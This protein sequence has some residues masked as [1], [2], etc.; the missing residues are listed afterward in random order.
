M[1]TNERGGCFEQRNCGA[2]E[3]IKLDELLLFALSPTGAAVVG[4]VSRQVEMSPADASGGPLLHQGQLCQERDDESILDEATQIDEGGFHEDATGAVATVMQGQEAERR[5]RVASPRR[6]DVMSSYSPQTTGQLA[7]QP[8]EETSP[9]RRAILER[10]RVRRV[11][12]LA[13]YA[14]AMVEQGEEEAVQRA[15]DRRE[16]RVLMEEGNRNVRNLV[17]LLEQRVAIAARTENRAFSVVERILNLME[18]NMLTVAQSP[19]G[20]EVAAPVPTAPTVLSPTSNT[21]TVQRP[22]NEVLDLFHDFNIMMQWRPD[23]GQHSRS[24]GI[25][26]AHCNAGK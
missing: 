25:L 18:R 20:V 16:F 22:R 6:E 11:G 1:A 14:R 24:P 5:G 4:P 21:H 26:R 8:Q 12:V 10:R 19:A 15:E 13:D 23:T 7:G 2:G 3:K 9:E 17:A